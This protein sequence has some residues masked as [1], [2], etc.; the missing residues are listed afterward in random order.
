MMVLVVMTHWL[1]DIVFSF[2]HF[3]LLIFL[4]RE[5]QT[6]RRL[7]SLLLFF[8]SLLL[9]SLSFLLLLLARYMCISTPLFTFSFR[10]CN[11]SLLLRWTRKSNNYLFIYKSPKRHDL[12]TPLITIVCVLI[13]FCFFSCLLITRI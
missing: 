4:S 11:S 2:L 10:C 13:C 3:A 5:T 1:I 6:K 12:L 8:F 9:L 7:L